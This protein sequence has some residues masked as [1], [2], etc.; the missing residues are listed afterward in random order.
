MPLCLSTFRWMWVLYR[1]RIL[2]GNTAAIGV[3][4][5]KKE[6]AKMIKEMRT[7]NFSINDRYFLK[8]EL[9]KANY[10]Q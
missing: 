6:G 9:F 2:D 3:F 8:K 7:N 1:K 10:E 5:T 4:H